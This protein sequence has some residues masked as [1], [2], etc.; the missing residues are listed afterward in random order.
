MKKSAVAIAV[1]AALAP[2]WQAWAAAPPDALLACGQVVDSQ[3]RLECFDR[4]LAKSRSAAVI[5]PATPVA[6]A[7]AVASTPIAAPPPPVSAPAK[8]PVAAA[9]AAP[10]VAAPTSAAS[11]FGAE[12]LATKEQKPL[13]EEQLKL[14]AKITSLRQQGTNNFYVYLDNGQVWRHEDI[15]LG[16]YLHQGDAVTI[17]KA[18]LGS[19]RLTRDAG[20]SRDWIRTT[21]VH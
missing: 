2:T 1:F 12:S 19:Y 10:A 20:A 11:S 3:A 7:A 16:S 17:S 5:P 8:A 9:A 18:T 15:H 13:P 14:H 21:R 6:P 4:E